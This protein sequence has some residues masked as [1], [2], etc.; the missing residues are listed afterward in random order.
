MEAI[1]AQRFAPLNFSVVPGFSNV[2]P[3]IDEWGEYLPRFR[4]DKDDNLADHLL[5][6]HEVI[7]YQ[8][9]I[10]DDDVLMKM[11]MYSL[12]G[13]ARKWYQSLPLASIYSLKKFHATFSDHCKR[14]FPAD[15]LL[16][17][18]VRSLIY[19]CRIL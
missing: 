7:G 1:L 12:A 17:I 6:F 4:E 9:A 5:E 8:L 19:V 2:V 14:F 18:V 3:T 15:L 13:D 11:F 16:K 10:H